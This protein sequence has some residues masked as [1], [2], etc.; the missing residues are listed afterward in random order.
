MANIYANAYLTIAATN[1]SDASGGCFRKQISTYVEG[2][3][4]KRKPRLATFESWM[5]LSENATFTAGTALLCPG[6]VMGL[7][8]FTEKREHRQRPRFYFRR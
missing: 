1:S 5:G 6:S 3:S 8:G 7:P 2:A 4:N